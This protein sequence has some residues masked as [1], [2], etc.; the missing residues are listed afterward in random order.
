MNLQGSK[1]DF[2]K[3]SFMLP[4]LNRN[5][6][7]Q[8]YPLNSWVYGGQRWIR[9]RLMLAKGKLRVGSGWFRNGSVWL[10]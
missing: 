5:Q 4:G 7:G 10:V 2:P 3:P 8:G 1:T 6:P 9:V